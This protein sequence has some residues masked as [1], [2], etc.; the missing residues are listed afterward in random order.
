FVRRGRCRILCAPTPLAGTPT[1]PDNTER[2]IPVLAYAVAA[3]VPPADASGFFD[4]GAT[5]VRATK[6]LCVVRYA[7]GSWA[8]AHD[9]GAVVLVGVASE[10]RERVVA[11]L[12]AYGG[13]KRAVTE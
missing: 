11:R 12:C 1:M 4:P 3:N 6:T 13:E 7:D 2:T 5:R 8:V 10:E 9:F